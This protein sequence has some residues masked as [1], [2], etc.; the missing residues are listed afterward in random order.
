[1]FDIKQ[2]HA[3]MSVPNMEDSI[4]WYENVFGFKLERRFHIPAT[5]PTARC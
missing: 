1:M 3:A 2:R 5:R 4:A